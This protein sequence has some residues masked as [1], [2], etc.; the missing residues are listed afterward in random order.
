MRRSRVPFGE[1]DPIGDM[2]RESLLKNAEKSLC[3]RRVLIGTLQRSDGLALTSKA[4]LR[5]LN[6]QFC[7]L[8][9]L[10]QCETAGHP[11]A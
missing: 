7:V 3:L 2:D 5:P 4:A 10:L 11:G 9:V 8:K 1:P 6:A